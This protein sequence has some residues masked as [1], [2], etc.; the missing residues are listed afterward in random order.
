M[1]GN[2]EVLTGMNTTNN[3]KRS[4]WIDVSVPLRDD[5]AVFKFENKMRIERRAS[6]ERG[7]HSNNSAIHM[8]VHTGTHL[9]APKHGIANGKSID[10]MPLDI[11][12]GPARVIEIKDNRTVRPEEIK[13]YDFKRGERILFKTLNS[14]KCWNTDNFVEDFV[15]ISPEAARFLVDAGVSL[16]GLDY[17]SVRAPASPGGAHETFFSAGVWLLEGLNLAAVKA[18]NYDLICL[19]LK[20]I[21]VEGSPVRAVLRPIP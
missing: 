21:Q 8:G 19:P 7:D 12:I 6:M 2:R 18:G 20:L 16:V 1:C 3:D 15:D 14:P 9:D 4:E 5:M 13:H 11:A 17:L 10:Q